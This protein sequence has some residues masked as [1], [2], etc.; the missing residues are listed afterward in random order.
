LKGGAGKDAIFGE[1]DADIVEGG[2]GDDYVEGG[3]GLDNYVYNPGDGKDRF[4]DIDGQ[5]SV[6]IA[7]TTIGDAF[8]TTRSLEWKAEGANGSDITLKFLGA[9][10]DIRGTLRIQGESLGGAGN[11]ID[12]VNFAPTGPDNTF[13]GI[14][15][16]SRK[17]IELVVGQTSNPWTEDGGHVAQAGADAVVET[18]G[19]VSV[20]AMG[21]AAVFDVHV[22]PVLPYTPVETRSI[23]ERVGTL[24]LSS[25]SP[26]AD[27]PVSYPAPDA[28][29]RAWADLQGMK[30]IPGGMAEDD[31]L[32]LLG[33]IA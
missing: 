8:R 19:A 21:K 10:T 11:Q 24:A 1:A 23:V 12:I 15:L 28:I 22:L 25:P 32:V 9:P 5:G 2:L 14:N 4:F 31:E 26:L 29:D 33:V 27:G 16:K 17:R 13:L 6:R 30:N 7:G 18:V 20:T 3:A